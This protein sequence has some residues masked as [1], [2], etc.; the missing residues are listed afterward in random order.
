MGA[1]SAPEAREGS[2]QPP[3]YHANAGEERKLAR[4]RNFALIKLSEFFAHFT[5]KRSF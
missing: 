1:R 5:V 2:W 4:A 3:S